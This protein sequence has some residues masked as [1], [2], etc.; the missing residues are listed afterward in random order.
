MWQCLRYNKRDA[1]N[2]KNNFCR[3]P[4]HFIDEYKKRQ[5]IESLVADLTL[6]SESER[7]QV[8]SA[9]IRLKEG[10]PDKQA[11]ISQLA[12]LGKEMWEGLGAGIWY[13]ELDLR[14]FLREERRASGQREHGLSKTSAFHVA[15]ILSSGAAC[16]ALFLQPED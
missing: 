7:E 14:N 11:K 2:S 10:R 1:G 13:A 4:N 5:N 6:L 15:T 8:M 16:R 9:L 12:G 3:M